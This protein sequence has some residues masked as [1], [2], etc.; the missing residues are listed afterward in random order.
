MSFQDTHPVLIIGF[1]KSI[2]GTQ[3]LQPPVRYPNLKNTNHSISN[4]LLSHDPHHNNVFEHEYHTQLPTS[5]HHQRSSRLH[6]LQQHTLGLQEIAHQHLHSSDIIRLL[7]V[8][9]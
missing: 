5:I 4:T 7:E 6:R 9:H 1:F 8:F 3:S 2:Y